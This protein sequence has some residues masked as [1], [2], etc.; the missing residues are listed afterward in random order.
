M[1]PEPHYEDFRSLRRKI[2]EWQRENAC[3][4]G[5][6]APRLCSTPTAAGAAAAQQRRSAPPPATA[7]GCPPAVRHSVRAAHCA[8][9]RPQRHLRAGRGAWAARRAAAQPW[10]QRP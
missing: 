1:E 9:P 4:W 5:R 6:K 2:F 10:R 8:A 7:V 3:L